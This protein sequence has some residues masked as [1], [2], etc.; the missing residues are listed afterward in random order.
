MWWEEESLPDFHLCI[1][2]YELNFYLT[3][4]E[5]VIY[6]IVKPE[7]CSFMDIVYFEGTLILNSDVWVHSGFVNYGILH[8]SSLPPAQL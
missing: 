2:F 6:N 1:P 3:G 7:G 8:Q 4:T 5:H